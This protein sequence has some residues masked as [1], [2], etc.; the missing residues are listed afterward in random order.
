MTRFSTALQFLVC[1]SLVGGIV[2]AAVAADD[3]AMPNLPDGLSIKL[4]LPEVKPTRALVNTGIYVPKLELK[5]ESD[6]PM[7]LWPFLDIEVLN[8][9]GTPTPPSMHIG[10]WG[11]ITAPSRI[12]DIKYVTLEPGKTYTMPIVLKGY[13]YDPHAIRAWRFVPERDYRV[14]LRYEFDRAKVIKDFGENCKVLDA[15]EQP[16]NK[17]SPAKWSGTFQLKL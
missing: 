9:D 11:L 3:V 4:V 8:A 1:C 7:T 15:P 12:E 10:R 6:A 16:W 5:N 2:H 14:N 17:I 13:S